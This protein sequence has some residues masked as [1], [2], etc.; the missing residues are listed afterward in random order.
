LM[1]LIRIISE[2]QLDKK[3]WVCLLRGDSEGGAVPPEFSA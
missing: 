2:W 3:L 1:T